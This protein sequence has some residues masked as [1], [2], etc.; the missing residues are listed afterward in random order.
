MPGPEAAGPGT[1]RLAQ[2]RESLAAVRARISSV[3]RERPAGAPEPELIVVSKFHPA[4]DIRLLMEL[5]AGDFGENR[6]Q[7][8]SAKAFELGNGWNHRR[9]RSVHDSSST[10]LPLRWHFV[11]QLQTNKAKSVAAYAAAVHS[12]DRPAL[13]R[14]LSKAIAAEQERTGRPD[15]LCF[16]QVNLDPAAGHPAP[17]SAGAP[18]RGG[19]HP[20]EVVDL[21]ALVDAAPGLVLAGVMAVAPQAT[22]PDEAF[23]RLAQISAAVLERFPDATSI[24]AGMSHDL[25]QAIRHGATHLRV[26]SDVLGARPALR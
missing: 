3:S 4:S 1:D 5:G 20:H 23:A 7:E 18:H 11:G 13:V 17:G 26:G 12:V 19:A 10:Q 14:E 25:E 22:D 9:Q 8:A 15:L 6:D 2:L 24:S 16:I 21:A